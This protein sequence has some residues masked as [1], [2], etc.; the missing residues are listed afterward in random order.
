[1]SWVCGPTIL[2]KFGLERVDN[3]P[4]LVQAQRRLGE[5]GNPFR[6]CDFEGSD[7]LYGRDHL[8]DL[9]SFAQGAFDLVVVPVADQHQRIA[10]SGELDRLH[11]DL[12]D[13]RAGGVDHL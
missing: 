7:F 4:R 2:G 13:Q 1:M 11:V 5:I 9:R 12:G 10:L 8:G 3:V 6:I